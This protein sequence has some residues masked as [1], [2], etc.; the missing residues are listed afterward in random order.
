MSHLT[1][2]ILQILSAYQSVKTLVVNDVIKTDGL[3]LIRM[4]LFHFN[5]LY[6]YIQLLIPLLLS[7]V[8]KRQTGSV[9][10][11]WI[12]CDVAGPS[13]ICPNCQ[14]VGPSLSASEALFTTYLFIIISLVPRTAL[15][16][17]IGE[18]D[19]TETAFF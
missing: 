17:R 16:Q 2:R 18:E 13:G 3:Q 1:K 14:I 15:T 10:T 8:V 11:I 4:K 7:S 12:F 9:K 19:R 5:L 6:S